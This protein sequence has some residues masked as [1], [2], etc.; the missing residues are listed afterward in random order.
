[1]NFKKYF[2]PSTLVAAAFIGPGTLTICTLAGANAGYTLLWALLFSII[3]TIVLQEMAARLGLVTQSGLGEAIR[4]EFSKPFGR[5]LS[6]AL[7]IGAIVIGNGAYEAGN[8]SGAVL[9][10]NV[11]IGDFKFMPLVIGLIAFLLL[12]TGNYK[13]I[14]RFLVGL[15]ILMSL[16]FLVT[17]IFIQPDWSSILKGLF[18][19]KLAS[20]DLFLVIGLIGTTVVPYNLFLHASSIQ[21]KWTSSDDLNA[22][23]IENRVAIIL[24]GI[25]SIC[26]VITSAAAF[27]NGETS[28]TNA[29]DMAIQLEPVLGN[30]AKYFMVLGLFAAGI[31]SA[32]TA[33]LAAAMAANG[34][35]GWKADFFKDYRFKAVWMVILIVGSLVATL[36]IKP[37]VIIQFAQVTNG[38]LLPVIASFLLYIMNKKAVLGKYTNSLFQN[39]LGIT[40]IL[41]TLFISFRS[42]NSVFHFL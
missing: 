31:T 20:N 33:P 16:V 36:G 42:M 29:A 13:L 27:Q 3:A 17:A 9:G 28:V 26:I 38:I 25:I 18:V 2:G 39:A 11:M 6:I 19:P 15:V 1:M 23:R 22:M 8:I 35:L 14:E 24:G 37:I 30:W 40:V 34:I 10:L 32:I 21:Q 5:L 7:I 4:Q 41:V 12:N